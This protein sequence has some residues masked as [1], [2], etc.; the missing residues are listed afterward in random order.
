MRKVL[1]SLV[2][3]LG[4]VSCGQ[5]PQRDNRTDLEW[6]CEEQTTHPDWEDLCLP[7]EE[8]KEEEEDT[9]SSR[10]YEYYRQ[11]HGL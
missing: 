11:K 1:V 10:K 4:L 9:N 6:F 7:L 8:G 3:G 5:A 2:F